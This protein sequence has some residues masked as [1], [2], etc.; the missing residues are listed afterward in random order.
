[1]KLKYIVLA[2]L[3]PVFVFNSCKR[4]T[5]PIFEK[6][7]TIR[8]NEAIEKAYQVLQGNQAGWMMKYYP[9]NSLDFGGY[10][11]F[12]KFISNAQVTLTSDVNEDVVTSTYGVVQE[13]GPVLTFNGYN[14]VIHFFSEPGMDNG[15]IGADDTGIK[16]DFEFIVLQASADSVVLKGKKSG[17]RI[18]MLPLQGN[19][20][21][22]LSADY[23]EAS[24][25][26]D[27]YGVFKLENQDG[28]LSDLLYNMRTFQ[29]VS[30]GVPTLHTFRVTPNG[31]EFY[32]E[33]ELGG[34]RFSTLSYVQ[35]T[36]T[37][38]LGYFTDSGN[39]IKVVPQ[40]TPL[41]LWFRNNLWS[42]SY[43]NV[44][45]TGRSY[46]NV[47]RTNLANNNI[48]LNNY[49]IG[50][51]QGFAGMVYILQNGTVGGLIT[52]NITL[53]P[54]TDNQVR[55]SL[56]G[57][58]YNLGGGFGVAYWSA[59]LNQLTTPFNNRTFTI[60]ADDPNKPNSVLLTDTAIPTNTFRVFLE[61]INDPFN[62]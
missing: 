16:G 50:N 8:V 48:R 15:G 12:A 43:S 61:D 28:E 34:V 32:R 35:P 17:N 60:T 47:A 4:E 29:D 39:L 9:S 24:R 1:M 30:G 27:D 33:V 46:W 49:Y 23:Q 57:S 22:E 7:A 40:A 19:Q 38:P 59:G 45:A 26:F 13:S 44:G 53:V 5:D 52:H 25:S 41:N 31:L 14:K 55:I 18:V 56:D 62:N 54:G 6:N 10:T 2:L 37:Y 3:L 11:I 21:E 58:I 42:L 36:E 20:F 51:Y